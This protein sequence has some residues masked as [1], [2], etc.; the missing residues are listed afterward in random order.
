MVSMFG[1]SAP[2]SAASATLASGP[3]IFFDRAPA[4][5]SPVILSSRVDGS[6]EVTVAPGADPALS[7]DGTKLAYSR[8]QPGGYQLMVLDFATG[9]PTQLTHLTDQEA[10]FGKGRYGAMRP[11]WSPDGRHLAFA[12]A[13]GSSTTLG[14]ISASGGA[15]HDLEDTIAHLYGQTPMWLA[16]SSG[17]LVGSEAGVHRVT[18]EGRDDGPI[19][20]LGSDPQGFVGA[21]PDGSMVFVGT[22]RGSERVDVASGARVSLTGD[23]SSVSPDGSLLA[24]VNAAVNQV[25]VTSAARPARVVY[26]APSGANVNSTRFSRDGAYLLIEYTQNASATPGSISTG[27]FQAGPVTPSGTFTAVV[28]LADGTL[29]NVTGDSATEGEVTL[30]RA[31]VPGATGG[32][33]PATGGSGPATTRVDNNNNNK[34]PGPVARPTKQ[35]ST[36]VAAIPTVKDVSKSGKVILINLVVVALLILLIT[37]PAQL[38]NSTLDEHY[39]EVRGWFRLP[40]RRDRPPAPRPAPQDVSRSRRIRLYVM[41]LA[42]TAILHGFLDP[43]FGLDAASATLVLGM[44]IGIPIVTLVSSAASL[45]YARV[46]HGDRGVMRVL[47]GTLAVGIVC[48]VISRLAHFAPGYLYGLIAG[49]AFSRK[50]SKEEEGRRAAITSTWVLAVSMVAWLALSPLQGHVIHGFFGF[51]FE[52]VLSSLT[53]VFLGGIEGMALG[54]V[55]MRTLTGEKIFR[56]NKAVWLALFAFALF[57]FV[58]LLLHP[59]S[60]FGAAEHP[61][62]LFTWLGLFIAFGA[63]SI[64]FWAYFRYRPA[65]PTSPVEPAASVVE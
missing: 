3:R 43:R 49:F 10:E 7:P 17:L 44:V 51:F 29:A 19:A 47:P 59:Q 41:F 38:F 11:L 8:Y 27:G 13:E 32:A 33:L 22:S 45:A 12:L 48:V 31:L 54:L 26:N 37:F 18:A 58:H 21:T 4:P 5:L 28:T 60:G 57:V 34:A 16:D 52:M 39:D 24:L 63:A 23:V 35:R 56:W 64:L 55:P 30:A 2:T 46:K 1:A 15:A 40:G 14:V 36:V 42:G 25:S 50:L 62:P 61:T 6:D 9:K 65:R 53:S 20:S